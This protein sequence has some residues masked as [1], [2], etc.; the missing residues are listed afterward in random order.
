[1]E[2]P[3]FIDR[4]KLVAFIICTWWTFWATM[5]L[6]REKFIFPAN[7]SHL[8]IMLS[9]VFLTVAF[10]VTRRASHTKRPSIEDADIRYPFFRVQLVFV[11]FFIVFICIPEIIK[12]PFGYRL[13]TFF[14]DARGIKSNIFPN[15]ATQFLFTVIF[16]YIPLSL[17]T[18]SSFNGMKK[19]FK[20]S[21]ILLVAYALVTLSRGIYLTILMAYIF[22]PGIR[23]RLVI[24]LTLL[25]GCMIFIPDYIE[26]NTLGFSLLEN[27]I[28]ANNLIEFPDLGIIGTFGGF[29]WPLLSGYRLLD[30]SH[31]LNFEEAASNN[32]AF[33]D[34]G[35]YEN[36]N[37]N[38][39]YTFM[40][41]P[42]FDFGLMA[43]FVLGLFLAIIFT[44]ITRLKSKFLY[45]SFIGFFFVTCLNGNQ[46]NSI[47]DRIIL[48]Y[49]LIVLV[50]YK[51]KYAQ[52]RKSHNSRPILQSGEIPQRMS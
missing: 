8:F 37:Y 29:I 27:F 16:Y 13:Y 3:Y 39:Y 26:Y 43:P 24:M 31:K 22:M 33:V 36:Y 50:I 10:V 20:Y 11:T 48:I 41:G 30:P 35:R 21:A 14:D 17:L 7:A 38:A 1:M 44:A 45:R 46:M 32:S 2:S 23:H 28:Q 9:F 25:L 52:Y 12:D 6:Y 42:V 18:I 4:P 49:I 5:A 47:G 34:I 40:Q 19:T 51:I 15:A